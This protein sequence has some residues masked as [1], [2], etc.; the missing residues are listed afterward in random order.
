M[1]LV[2]TKKNPITGALV[3]ADIV[4]KTAVQAGSPDARAMQHDI[5]HFCRGALSSHKVP[6]AV[7][8][9]PSLAIAETGKLL[10][11]DA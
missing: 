1:S 9:V 5:L 11:R 10:R 6:A 2:R 8:F 4:L 3:V 7:Y